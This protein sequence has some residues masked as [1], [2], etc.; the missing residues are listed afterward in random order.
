[1]DVQKVKK[2]RAPDPASTSSD[3]VDDLVVKIKTM[4]KR[5][6]ASRRDPDQDDEA[7]WNFAVDGFHPDLRMWERQPGES[8]Q[9]FEAF[10]LYRDL[11]AGRSLA[12]VG[13][14]AGKDVSLMER[15]SSKWEWVTRAEAYDRYLDQQ[16]VEN[17]QAAKVEMARRMTLVQAASSSACM[18]ALSIPAI[19]LAE[20]FQEPDGRKF[21]KEMPIEKLHKLVTSG[22]PALVEAARLQ[23]DVLSPFLPDNEKGL[24]PLTQLHYQVGTGPLLAALARQAPPELGPGDE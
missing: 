19:V 15:W 4:E 17:R 8:R 14:R 2:I 22:M 13:R 24:D 16:A 23:G 9:A 7:P 3:S 18:Q 11:E 21:L 6:A 20:R 10:T 1:M 12:K 5:Q